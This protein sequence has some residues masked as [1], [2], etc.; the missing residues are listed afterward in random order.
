MQ[1]LDSFQKITTKLSNSSLNSTGGSLNTDIKNIYKFKEILGGGNFGTV[2]VGYKKA[3]GESKKYAIKSISKKDLSPEDLPK[4]LREV[5]ILSNLDH[6]NIIKLAETYEDKYYL[7]IVTALCTGKEM[8]SRLLEKGKITEKMVA[9]MIFK[10][11]SAVLYLHDNK[12]THRDIKPENILFESMDDD[13][14]IKLIDFGLSRKYNSNEK[15]HTK[16][17]TPYY[18]SPEV[19]NGVYDEKCDIWSVGVLTFLMLS[20]SPPFMSST[21]NDK[22]LYDKIINTEP[23]F[24]T[25]KWG[26]ISK[27][28]IKFVKACLTKNPSSRPNAAE[29]INHPWFKSVIN[30]IHSNENLSVEVLEHLRNFSSNECFKRIILKFLVN[31]LSQNELNKL[32]KV[33][34]AMDLDHTGTLSSE[35]LAKAFSLASIKISN[36]EIEQI[37]SSYDNHL[38]NF[39]EFVI[40]SLDH[41]KIVNKEK[42]T[43]AFNYFD[44]D[45]S[46]YI[47]AS[48]LENALLRSGKKIINPDEIDRIIEEVSS[49]NDKKVISIDEFYALF[50]AKEEEAEF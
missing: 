3:E 31:M 40:S 5:E 32:K 21:K 44:V 20:G 29:A 30:E 4:L 38:M 28:A 42:L 22:D 23:H 26:G 8:F 35:E 12:I 45:G 49:K 7:H 36:E 1:R 2:R 24:S 33:F 14:E 16:I 13:A 19:L 17:G 27:N 46:G 50:P 10:V 39:T 11:M 48:D 41:K 43:Y 34:S 9:A 25:K 47:D 37:M 18:V 15:M 6:P